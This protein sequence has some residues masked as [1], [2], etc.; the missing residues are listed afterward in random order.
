MTE[1]EDFSELIGLTPAEAEALV[2][3]A[4]RVTERDNQPLVVTRDYRLDRINVA[5][6][7]GKIVS[8]GRRG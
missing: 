1:R 8:V 4:I 6:V 5:T 2:E 7:D 3:G